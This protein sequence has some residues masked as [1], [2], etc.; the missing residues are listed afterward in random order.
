MGRKNSTK[1]KPRPLVLQ[2]YRRWT[3]DTVFTNKKQLKGTR[4]V[5]TEL[6]TPENLQLFKKA[7]EIFN[8]Q[9]WTYNGFVYVETSGQRKLIK[10]DGDLDDSTL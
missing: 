1:N 3:R 7:R 9:A 10:C 5:I 2:F 6:L 4:I 8:Q